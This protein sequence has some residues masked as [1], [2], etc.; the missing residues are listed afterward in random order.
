MSPQRREGSLIQADFFQNI[1]GLNN[2]DSPFAVKENQSIFG[3][4][5][6]YTLD[7]GILKRQG[8]YKLN[9]SADAQLKSLGIGLLN[10]PTGTK[11]VVR[12]AGTKIQSF[13]ITPRIFTNMT[14]DTAAAPSDFLTSGSTVRVI[15]TQFNTTSASALWLCGGGLGRPHGVYSSTKVTE[16]GVDVPTGAISLSQ[17]AGTGTFPSTGTF[18]Y[19]V[20]YTKASTSAESNV[21][22]EESI[23][24]ASATN[25]VVID[26]TGLTSLD[27]TLIGTINIYRSAVNGAEGFTT[28]DLIAQLASTTTSYTDTGSSISDSENIPRSGNTILDNTRLSAG[29]YNAITTWKRRLVTSKDSTLEISDLNKP[30][31]FPTVNRITVPSGGNITGFGVLSSISTS[32]D[33]SD[34][35]LAIFKERELWLLTGND[36]DDWNLVYVDAVG[37]PAQSL[38]VNANSYLVWVDARGVHMWKG[39]GKPLFLSPTIDSFWLKDGALD[40]S[41]ITRGFGTFYRPTSTVLWVLSHKIEGENKVALKLNLRHTLPSVTNDLLGNIVEG[42]FT[43][44]TMA[45]ELDAM[46]A[47]IPPNEQD[48]TLLGGDNAGFMY[49]MF[50]GYNDGGS[51]I[52]F[53]YDTSW[54][55]FGSPGTTKRI[56]KVI[57]WV[58]AIGT[59][60]LK[61]DFWSDYKA[62][63]T[64][65]AAITQQIRIK[66]DTE[67]A[68]WDLAQWDSADWDDFNPRYIP[69]VYNIPIN[70]VKKNNEGDAFRFRFSNN[71][72]DQPIHI[73]GFSVIYSEMGVGH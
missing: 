33:S 21:A 19:V 54:L 49:R 55:N 4:N 46:D 61:L 32:S 40:I 12:A 69:L 31:S 58:R 22:L 45:M 3:E 5:W 62:A 64:D 18:R 41:K 24:L 26:L 15:K 66:D 2:S 34:E 53:K 38:I 23:A 67:T 29:T 42:I 68:L 6:D 72:A 73:A 17:I 7:G 44:D 50:D 47:M 59:W 10:T 37:C 70:A 8:H 28:G 65:S 9:S 30:E 27:T 56:H 1:G 48:E 13:D 43:I 57:V 71:G 11:T 52:D 63:D 20:S 36:T 14:K 60:N 25:H 35:Y 39:N 16:N 51:A